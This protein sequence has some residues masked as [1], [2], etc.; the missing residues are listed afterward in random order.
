V[1]G[2]LA[3]LDPLLGRP[4]LDVEADDCSVRPQRGDDEA[5]SGK[6]FTEVMLDLGDHAA[7][8]VPGGGLI[9]EA[10]VADQRGVARLAARPSE[11]VPDDPLKD[12]V[13]W[14]ANRISHTSSFERLIDRWR[15]ERRV[16]PDDDGVALRAVPVNNGRSTSSHPAALWTLPGRSLAA[17]QSPCWLKTKR[18][19]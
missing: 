8:A 19:W 10:A 6:Q 15:G 3:L 2:G 1:G 11:Q 12:V 13:G 18:G 17:R 16:G 9:V 4:A 7:R 14:Q 5:Y